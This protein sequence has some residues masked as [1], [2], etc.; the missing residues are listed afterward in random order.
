MNQTKKAILFALVFIM[1]VSMV[2]A[3]VTKRRVPIKGAEQPAPYADSEV[4]VKFIEGVDLEQI[5]RFARARGLAVKK[6]YGFL[7]QR[8]G[9]QLVLLKSEMKTDAKTLG[10]NLAADLRVVYAHPNYRRY[11][12]N[13]YP[14]DTRFAELWGLHNT[15]QTLGTA[16]ADIDAP[17]AWDIS[18]GSSSVIVAVIDSGLDYNHDDL[19]HNA[20]K[21][22]GEIAGNGIDDDNNGYIDDIYG[23]DPAG[24][25][26][27]GS[28]PDVDPMDGIGHGT[29]C[30]GTISGRGNNGLGVAGV[31]WNA[32][33]MALKFFGDADGG[34]YDADAI[35]C[36]QY[37]IY[38]KVHGQNV[39][40]INASW[41]GTGGTDSGG[42][43]DAIE[44]VTNVG[45]VFCAAAGN[46][47]SDGIGDDN[48]RK[49]GRLNH[50]YPS[51]YT[52]PGI[53]SVAATDH[54][55]AL[56][57]FSNY[58][59]TSVDLG[60]PGVAVLSTV[61]GM[62]IPQD[63]DIFFDD[64]ESVNGNWTHDAISGTDY[65]QITT[66]QESF[67]NASFPVPSPP[68][69]WS[70]RPGADYANNSN[71]WL[72]Y[73]ADIDLSAYVGQDLYFGIGSALAFEV[74]DHGYIEFSNNSGSTWSVIHDFT[75]EG[76]YWSRWVW[77]IP[78]SFKT[79]QF[80]MRFRLQSDN[81]G[82]TW[83]GWLIDNIG[84]GNSK[85]YS[86]ESW[87]G[88][89]MATP[90]VAGAVAWL[91]AV[92]PDETVAQRKERIL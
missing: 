57:D 82:T 87:G 83:I 30:S 69:F 59:A 12:A 91:A 10:T 15:G 66:D 22:P 36:M 52:L 37:A 34:G 6:H 55:D 4:L 63:G 62:Y 42:L 44:V 13:T 60:A 49:P 3:V 61:P 25:D 19:K 7:S 65:W 39:T 40:A 81:D 56:A 21:N 79:S 64:M 75:N 47:G 58:G 90:H 80:R 31:N 33:I 18:T 27:S 8:M 14:N 26:G 84:I 1:T 67:A 72:A 46:G 50:H 48:D 54:A 68:N 89:S 78:D 2:F 85:S 74:N 9:Q 38:Q 77:L 76:W 53:I 45:I 20:W 51:D 88:T 43:R 29:H 24:A 28:N 70:D 35:E 32:R 17:E 16:D 71:T 41:G 73:N 5:K 86:Y 92:F 23:I 11:M